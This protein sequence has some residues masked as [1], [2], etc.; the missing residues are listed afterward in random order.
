MRLMIISLC[1][2]LWIAPA[3]A[4]DVPDTGPMTADRIGAI[5][6]GIDTETLRQGNSYILTLEN[7]Q[8]QVVTDPRADRMRIMIPITAADNVAPEL[9][10]RLLQA[11]FDTALDARYAFA[12]DIVWSTYIHPLSVLTDS[13]F[14]DGLAQTVTAALTFGDTFTSGAFSFGG[15]DSNQL[16]QDLKKRWQSL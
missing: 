8:V 3:N 4:Q 15:G 14:I 16:L 5:L 2:L 13:Q 1:I 11:N 9:M 7:Q 6:A 10:K 12:R